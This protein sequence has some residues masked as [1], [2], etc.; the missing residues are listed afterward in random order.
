M[1]FRENTRLT[2][3][4]IAMISVFDDKKLRSLLEDFYRIS[5]I[6]IT[7]FDDNL[8]EIISYPDDVA[9][10]CRIIRSTESGLSEC[11]RCDAEALRKASSR[12]RTYVYRC[13]AGLTEAITPLYV[14]EVL[15]GYLMFGHVFSYDN[16]AQ[17]W[18]VVR[19]CCEDLHVDLSQL[20]EEIMAAQPIGEEYVRSAAKILHA[21]ASYLIMERMATLKEDELAVRLDSFISSHYTEQLT[22]R[23][24]CEELSIGKTQLYKLSRQLYGCGIAEHI[25]DLRIESAKELLRSYRDMPLAEI[26]SRCGYSD[27]NY[28]IY[29]FSKEEGCPPAEWRKS[30]M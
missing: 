1:A 12:H 7:V 24:I 17:G 19:K 23:D 11:R 18:H 16:H 13:H 15:V 20:E 14:G 3:R 28:F 21:V 26:A 30:S 2:L 25:R 9:P 27:Y 10:Y 5:N 4:G 8:H 22:A 6:R 29:V